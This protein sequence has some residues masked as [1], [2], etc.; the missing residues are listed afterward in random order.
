MTKDAAELAAKFNEWTPVS[1]EEVAVAAAAMRA[2][3]EEMIAQPLQF[4]WVQ[5]A[6]AGLEAA[7]G[8]RSQ[9]TSSATAVDIAGGRR[10][11]R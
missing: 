10:R 4:C 7:A 11:G 8:W 1:S 5:I 9:T 6:R 3:R 2:K